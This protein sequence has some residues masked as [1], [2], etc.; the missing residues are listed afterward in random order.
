MGLIVAEGFS[1]RGVVLGGKLFQPR[2]D[3]VDDFVRRGSPRREADSGWKPSWASF[4]TARWAKRSSGQVASN[5]F[6]PRW[7]MLVMARSEA[8]C[9]VIITV[10]MKTIPKS[11]RGIT[12][13][14]SDPGS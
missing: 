11:E 7:R 1:R 2:F 8:P 10:E 6:S 14:M 13:R 4:S 9:A 5:T 3:A 12:R